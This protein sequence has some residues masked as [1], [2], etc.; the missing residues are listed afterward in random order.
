MKLEKLLVLLPVCVL[1]SHLDQVFL[2]FLVF[3]VFVC[4]SF[5]F[6]VSDQV[7][8]FAPKSSSH[9][10]IHGLMSLELTLEQGHW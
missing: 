5:S 6:Q 2:Q 7:Q 4:F 8:N 1:W 3:F 9:M 10:P